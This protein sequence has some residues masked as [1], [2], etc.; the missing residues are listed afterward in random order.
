MPTPEES[1]IGRKGFGEVPKY[2]ARIKQ[3]VKKEKEIIAE[4]IAQ[5]EVPFFILANTH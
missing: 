3:E 5:E 1:A 2:L 4:L